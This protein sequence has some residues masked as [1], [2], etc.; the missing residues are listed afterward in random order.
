MS[1]NRSTD[2]R[3]TNASARPSVVHRE[4]VH[5]CSFRST[6]KRRR[7]TSNAEYSPLFRRNNEILRI[8]DLLTQRMLSKTVPIVSSETAKSPL[9]KAD[10]TIELSFSTIAPPLSDLEIP[11]D[12]NPAA[13]FAAHF[14]QNPKYTRLSILHQPSTLD[15]FVFLVTHELPLSARSIAVKASDWHAI[16]V[17]MGTNSA[18]TYNYSSCSK[19]RKTRND[20][21]LSSSNTSSEGG[22]DT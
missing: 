14:A 5:R 18:E 10:E 4:P 3:S 8:A 12:L 22:R 16:G 7:L 19:C 21:L 15:G 20:R 6:P 2:P 1:L 9:G 17:S 13:A 11:S